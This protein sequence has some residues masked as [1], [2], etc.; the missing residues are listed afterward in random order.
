VL[1]RKRKK[2]NPV[3]DTNTKLT[4]EKINEAEHKFWKICDYVATLLY[5][6]EGLANW[7]V[8]VCSMRDNEEINATYIAHKNSCKTMDVVTWREFYVTDQEVAQLVLIMLKDHGFH[9]NQAVLQDKVDTVYIF[10]R[11]KEQVNTLN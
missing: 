7:Y 11:Q 5:S 8:G 4:A 6:G 3:G 9:V 1:L 2:S 10:R